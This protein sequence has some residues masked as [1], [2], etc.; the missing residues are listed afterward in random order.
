MD[1]TV[2]A[3]V[4]LFI[5]PSHSFDYLPGFLGGCAIVKIAYGMTVYLTGEYGEIL[6][7]F[8][9]IKIHRAIS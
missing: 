6:S 9:N 5:V 1:A 2:Y 3:G 4:F 8:F 7:D